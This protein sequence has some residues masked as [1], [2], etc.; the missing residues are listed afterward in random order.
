MKILEKSGNEI[1]L[2]A[3]PSEGVS[4]GEYILIE[5][6]AQERQMVVQIYDESYLDLSEL[7]NDLVREEILNKTVQRIELDPLEIKTIS[8]LIRDMKLL[9]CKIRGVVEGGRLTPNLSWL[10]SRV[11]SKVK[12][13]SISDLFS[14]AKRD[15]YRKLPVGI[16]NDGDG[17]QIYAEAL[18]GRLNIITGKKGTGK[19][20]LAKLIINMLVEH[21]AYIIV[22]D[23]NDEYKGIGWK[24][25]GRPNS[26]ADKVFNLIPGKSLRF[27]LKYIG[28]SGI[29]SM[30]QH[31]L[32]IP[33]ASLR[34]FGR[35]W[36][37]LEAQGSVNMASFI[38]SIQKW[39]CNE[40]VKDAL[41]SRYHTMLSSKLFSDEQERTIRFEDLFS[42]YKQGG[43]FII[44]LSRLQPQVRKIVVE[45]ILGKIVNLL[46]RGKIPPIFL[47]A[48][49]AH[50][51]LRETYWDD[52][53][54][55]MRHFGIFTTFI[56]NQPD[57]IKDCIYR[58]VDN[59][60]IFNFT[61]DVDL[62]TISRISTVDS[63]TV[64]AIVKTL[65]PRACMVLGKA[66]NEL[67]I[68]I[69]VNSTDMLT[70]GET[71]LFFKDYLEDN[72]KI[73]LI[74]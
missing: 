36:E 30:L 41:F 66:V 67:P 24:K 42:K 32:D 49:E 18:D 20:H 8:Y 39:R 40:F 4:R 21:G 13:L 23:L 2:L 22:F 29:A 14:L 57:V 65:P 68:I 46:G 69:E 58:Q 59:L 74:K 43:V 11:T 70:L 53:V 26:I 61:N 15:G 37:F 44:S 52:I 38:N 73:K 3:L 12:K 54:T 9:R 35:I 62:E 56:T 5:D 31:A 7:V 72:P 48:E 27:S 60:F 19:S 17:F 33:G 45:L 28:L 64:K 34:E 6:E 55:R 10:P 25:N 71:N 51:Y 47:F 50:L 1:L 63:D 16:T